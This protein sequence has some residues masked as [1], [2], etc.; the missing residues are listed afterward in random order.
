MYLAKKLRYS[1]IILTASLILSC[2]SPVKV[3]KIIDKYPNDTRHQSELIIYFSLDEIEYSYT[4]IANIQLENNAI[5][6]NLLYDER[7]KSYLLSRIND[8]GAD[9]I[10]YDNKNSDSTYS[11]FDAIKYKTDLFN[12]R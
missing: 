1:S 12:N 4:V 5:Y 10:I 11:Y 8:I 9:A 7:I 2:Y 6:G 3:S